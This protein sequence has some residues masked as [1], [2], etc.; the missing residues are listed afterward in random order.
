MRTSSLERKFLILWNWQASAWPEPEREVRF[1]PV[2]RWRFDFAWP[3]HRVA[4]EMDGGIFTGGRHVRGPQY[5]AGCEKRNAAVVLGWR[6][7]TYT[8]LDIRKRPTQM[9]EEIIS[10]LEQ[11]KQPDGEDQLRLFSPKT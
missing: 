1:H 4:V 9:I 11:G 2:R 5:S 7:L 8:T 3:A 6:V 10:L